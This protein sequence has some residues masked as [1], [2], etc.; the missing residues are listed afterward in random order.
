M[1]LRVKRVM[2]MENIFLEEFRKFTFTTNQKKIANYFMN[3]QF[4]IS[5]KTLRETAAEAGVSEVSILNFVRKLGFDGFSSFKNWVH[6]Q[7]AQQLH[8]SYAGLDERFRGN[9]E[10]RTSQNL[11]VDHLRVELR[12]IQQSLEQNSPETYEKT[13]DAL[14]A[15]GRIFV[16]GL[17]SVEGL[18][19]RFARALYYLF[20][21]VSFLSGYYNGLVQA[22]SRVK[23][24]DIVLLLC[25]SRYYKT[26]IALCSMVHELG[27][28]LILISDSAVSPVAVYADHLLVAT[29]D[30]ISFHHSMAGL[31]A[32]L[33]YLIVLLTERTGSD[34]KSYWDQIDH[35]TEEFRFR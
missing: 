27:A 14:A 5:Q 15:A 33:E 28:N 26:D 3:H 19:N 16:V 23:K 30:S 1:L 18:A 32:I 35:Y 4:E 17:G 29:T 22:L 8:P 31:L 24:G 6:E 9:R 10:S 12:N 7:I 11:L 25:F 34:A 21:N 20:D 13:A 2:K